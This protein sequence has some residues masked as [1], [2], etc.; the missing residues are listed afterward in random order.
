MKDALTKIHKHMGL[1]IMVTH[2][3][4]KQTYE[5]NSIALYD[6]TLQWR[7]VCLRPSLALGNAV[8]WRH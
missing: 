2:I 3:P 6:P 8:R 4:N 5:H 7:V 1:C